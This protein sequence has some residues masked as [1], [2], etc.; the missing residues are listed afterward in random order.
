MMLY[1]MFPQDIVLLN[2]YHFQAYLDGFA[3][4]YLQW[5]DN[6]DNAVLR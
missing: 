5:A 1:I 2:Y 3:M 6:G 4:Q